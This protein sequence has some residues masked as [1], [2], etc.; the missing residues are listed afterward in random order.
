MKI[1]LSLSREEL[2]QLQYPVLVE[3]WDKNSGRIRREYNKQFTETERELVRRYYSVFYSWYLKSGT[4]E[5]AVMLPNTLD[6]LRRAIHFFAT[7]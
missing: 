3:M 6:I 1:M 7:V 5:Q 4:P 2:N